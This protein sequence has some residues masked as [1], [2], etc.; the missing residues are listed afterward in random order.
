MVRDENIRDLC[1]AMI[2]NN[3]YDPP[4]IYTW[5]NLTL[6]SDKERV[7]RNGGVSLLPF[8]MDS[9]DSRAGWKID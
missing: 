7:Q 2:I 8:F 5:D 6:Y 9:L 1:G 3:T 4:V